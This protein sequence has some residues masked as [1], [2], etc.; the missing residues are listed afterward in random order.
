MRYQA[1]LANLQ[2]TDWNP[3]SGDD[4]RFESDLLR[5]WP[6]ARAVVALRYR[7]RLP[8]QE[9]GQRRRL[10]CM[11]RRRIRRADDQPSTLWRMHAG[12]ACAGGDPAEDHGP[13]AEVLCAAWGHVKAGQ[14][15]AMLENSDLAAAALDNQGALRRRQEPTRPATK[16]QV[17][18]D[19]QKAELDLA[20]A[21]A[22]LDLQQKIVDA[23]ETAVRRGS[24]PG[25]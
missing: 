5:L 4:G 1:A 15:L 12:A 21:K 8:V 2:T 3:L 7:G 16:A 13:G 18:E 19:Y 10:R 25:A 20:Q 9:G 11:C 22:N 24:D 14:L 6:F 17:P 23:R